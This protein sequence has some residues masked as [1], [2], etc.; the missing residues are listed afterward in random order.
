MRHQS[1][2][3]M[4]LLGTQIFS[5]GA[6]YQVS[7]FIVKKRSPCPVLDYV[8]PIYSIKRSRAR[9]NSAF[10]Y[11]EQDEACMERKGTQLF[12]SQIESNDHLPL[13]VICVMRPL[14]FCPSA[15]PSVLY[16]HEFW[17]PVDL[18]RQS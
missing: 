11:L 14:C 16:G 18:L 8:T 15:Q 12:Y 17:F 2:P 4:R 5:D 9:V 3:V 10:L 6:R 1:Y 7:V 13:T